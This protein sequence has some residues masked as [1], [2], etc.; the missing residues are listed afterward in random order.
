MT[1]KK[2]ENNLLTLFVALAYSFLPI[3][4]KDGSL[5]WATMLREVPNPGYL[6]STAGS[7]RL[8]TV[9]FAIVV[10][11]GEKTQKKRELVN[12]MLVHWQVDLKM[13]QKPKG[14]KKCEFY[15]PGSQNTNLC[16]FFGHMAKDNDWLW[17]DKDFKG[18][19]GC[20][21]GCLAVWLRFTINA[22]KNM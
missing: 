5:K 15:A 20:L 19:P 11:A 3:V 18:W 17:K 6:K 13:E 16:T 8:K 12:S 1:I 9:P 4:K 2:N 22:T 7:K 14:N 21:H 10:G